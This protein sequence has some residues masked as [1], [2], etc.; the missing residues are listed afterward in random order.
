[1]TVEPRLRVLD[2]S[3]E[4]RERLESI[5]RKIDGDYEPPVSDRV[6]LA[7]YARKLW[8]HAINIVADVE[9]GDV[10]FVSM[11]ANDLT[12]RQAFITSI[13]VIQ[14]R[15]GSGLAQQLIR[16]AEDLARD[17]GMR[18]IRLEV[19]IENVRAI[20]FYAKMGFAPVDAGGQE[21]SASVFLAK[22]LEERCDE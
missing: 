18:R 5:L 22:G 20:R 13:G 2:V 9:G 17:R 21:G 15:W 1:M 8:Q 14:E 4:S 16:T 19:S 12:S 3:E 7:D 10:G 6:D 11:Y